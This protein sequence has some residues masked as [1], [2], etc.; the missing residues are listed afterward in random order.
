MAKARKALIIF[1]VFAAC[2]LVALAL[3]FLIP[4]LGAKTGF[5]PDAALDI[6]CAAPGEYTLSWPE[7]EGALDYRVRVETGGGEAGEF[8]VQGLSAPLSGIAEGEGVKISVTPLGRWRVLGGEFLRPGS[9]AIEASLTLTALEIP[10]VEY[11][12]DEYARTL[13]ARVH[14]ESGLHYELRLDSPWG[15]EVLVRSGG[16]LSVSFGDDGALP[17]PEYGE[18]LRFLVRAVEP[19]ERCTL[20]GEAGEALALSREDL[21]P[22]EISLVRE[23]LGDNHY[24]FTWNE[25]KGEGYEVQRSVDGQ[26][27][28]VESVG[29]D[30][31][32]EY[33]TGMLPSCTE[34]AYRVISVGGE[35]AEGGQFASD[36]GVSVFRTG[37]ESLYCTI[38]PLTELAFY[39]E[40]DFDSE[41][42]GS[43]PAATMLSVLGEENGLFRVRYSGQYGYI[44]SNYCLINLPEYMGDLLSYNITNSYS[45]LY[46]VHGYEIPEV[47]G[48]VV[49]GYEHVQLA[50]GVYL[51]PYLY[52]CCEKLY[53]AANAAIE[54]GYRLKIY[55]SYRPNMAT[56][57]IYEKAELIADEPVPELDIYGE[58]PEELPELAEGEALTYVRLWTEGNYGLPNFLAKGGSMHNMGIA[59]DLTLESLDGEELEMQSDMHDLSVYSIISRNNSEAQ[60]LDSIMKGAGFGGL[61]SEWWHFQDNETRQALGL[62]IYM[63]NGVSAEGWTADDTG[64]RYRRADGSFVTG[65]AEIGGVSYD[66]GDGGYCELWQDG[67]IVPEEAV[68][69][70]QDA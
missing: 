25:A 1:I 4:W 56:K 13:T 40:P 7:A 27:Q 16:T 20:T 65:E 10:E 69:A 39:T 34:Q 28:T 68:G 52:P 8:D 63:W 60:T 43:I 50:E 38:W 36:P 19:L 26:W 61:T 29:R 59:L 54:Q 35:I 9:G 11:T 70:A 31:E 22:G 2:V 66:F 5:S 47:T 30:G 53:N 46:A 33:L 57:D 42:L 45:S 37:L 55:D 58:V 12:V 51:A 6:V 48:E 49:L 3:T 32:R 24:A 17:M 23:E 62:N 67:G 64:W 14:G 15:E 44:D 21:L 18:E 41:Q